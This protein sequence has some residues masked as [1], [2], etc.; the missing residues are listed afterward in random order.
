MVV[1]PKEDYVCQYIRYGLWRLWLSCL[2]PDSP[3]FSISGAAFS[4]SASSSLRIVA[5]AMCN[6]AENIRDASLSASG[7]G[8]TAWTRS[9]RR[10]IRTSAT[11]NLSDS[12]SWASRSASQHWFKYPVKGKG[13]IR[14]NNVDTLE[15]RLV[16]IYL[17]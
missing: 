10:C 5:I 2:G 1:Y 9:T 16:N 11:S 6:G 3:L 14:R 17:L 7:F 4:T 12:Y 15:K 8:N 13:C